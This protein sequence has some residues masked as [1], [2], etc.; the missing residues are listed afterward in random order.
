MVSSAY[1]NTQLLIFFLDLVNFFDFPPN[2]SSTLLDF[3]ETLD[4][5]QKINYNMLTKAEP[6]EHTWIQNVS[7]PDESYPLLIESQF[8]QGTR[9]STCA[10]FTNLLWSQFSSKT[11]RCNERP[12]RIYMF[13]ISAKKYRLLWS[14][15]SSLLWGESCEITASH[16][17]FKVE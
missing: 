17:K 2:D 9:F 6:V 14:N 12:K 16:T 11:Y 10:T 13:I 4:L 3:F 1:T 8:G 7:R 15:R 5:D